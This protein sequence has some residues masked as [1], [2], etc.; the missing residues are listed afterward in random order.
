MTIQIQ[1][2]E[3]DP[4]MEQ[5]KAMSG[6]NDT[7]KILVQAVAVYHTLLRFSDDNT[8]TFIQDGQRYTMGLTKEADDILNEELD[9]GA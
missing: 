3:D 5:I 7:R 9:H 1:V 4:L 6:C 2:K 8:V